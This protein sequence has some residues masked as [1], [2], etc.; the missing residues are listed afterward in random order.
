MISEI[1]A[2]LDRKEALSDFE[3]QELTNTLLAYSRTANMGMLNLGRFV[4]L[5][6]ISPNATSTSTNP[7]DTGFTGAFQSGRGETFTEGTFNLGAVKAGQI[8]AGF[9]TDGDFLAAGGAYVLNQ[10]GSQVTGVGYLDIHDATINSQKRYLQRGFVDNITSPSYKIEFYGA[11]SSFLTITNGD[12]ATLDMT[13]WTASSGGILDGTPTTWSAANGYAEIQ[14]DRL[15]YVPSFES[16]TRFAV[17]AGE[18]YTFTVDTYGNCA[19]LPTTIFVSVRF[20]AAASGGCT[21]ATIC[22]SETSRRVSPLSRSVIQ[23]PSSSGA[24]RFSG[25]WSRGTTTP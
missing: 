16:A 22:A 12:F 17:T 8:S 5:E 23:M 3:R 7:T 9:N 2:K 24:P 25:I 4:G 6:F 1:V 11:P 15:L 14:N 10:Y 19:T 21:D 13:G 18:T 20:W